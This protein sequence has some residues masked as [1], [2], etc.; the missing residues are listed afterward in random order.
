[1]TKRERRLTEAAYIFS[2]RSTNHRDGFYRL[3]NNAARMIIMKTEQFAVLWLLL[4]SIVVGNLSVLAALRLSKARK[5]RTNFFIMHLALADLSVGVIS[6]LTD[7]VWKST[8]SWHAG[9]LGCKAVR[10][11]QVLVTLL[12]DLRGW[13]PSASTDTMPSHTL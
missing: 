11:A 4:L 7:L 1:M 2:N 8:V 5:S 12:L 3:A 6:V 13:W 10:F 9:N